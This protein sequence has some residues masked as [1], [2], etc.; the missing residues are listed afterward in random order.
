MDLQ[1]EKCL[2]K[3]IYGPEV[4]FICNRLIAYSTSSSEVSI[5]LKGSW[6]RGTK[7]GSS[8]LE[9]STVDCWEKNIS[10]KSAFSR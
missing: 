4:L 1:T 3:S 2:L 10:N 5:L 8:L 9:S 6:D 7:M